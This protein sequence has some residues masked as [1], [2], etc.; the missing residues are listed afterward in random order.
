MEEE[1]QQQEENVIDLHP[2]KKW[3]RILV[4]LG[5]FF[6]SF[7]LSFILFNV[8][9]FPLAKVICHTG[10]KQNQITECE[11]TA[12]NLLFNQKILFED[13]TYTNFTYHVNYTFKVF[14]SYYAFDQESGVDEN[15]PQYGHKLENEVIRHYFIDIKGDSA[16]Y[17]SAFNEYNSDN[18][19]DIGDTP[20]SI[21]LKSEY[22]NLLGSEL[23]EVKDEESYSEV[24]TNFRDHLF[25]RLFYLKVY[26]DILDNDLIVDGVSYNHN[27]NR[28]KS[29]NQQLQWVASVSCM[30]TMLLS[31][32]IFYIL[33]PCLHKDRKTLT[34]MVM[35]IEPIDKKTLASVRRLQIV[36][37]SFYQIVTNMAYLVFLPV[38]YFGISYCFNL[39]LL[40]AFSLIS[41]VYLIASLFIIIFNQYNQSG[42]DLLSQIVLIPTSELD[43]MYKPK[44]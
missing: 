42:S 26:Q 6:I 34:T 38:L 4:F 1:L 44:E 19:F 2:V 31:W 10:D 29:I 39:P 22:R 11:K 37:N 7:I 41:V 13:K 43:N 40:F 27:M 23:L 28:I 24:M 9:I 30:I 18:Y 35:N 5:D 20:E 15:H 16:G 12:N 21:S 36:V 32:S 33:I 17:L 3:K 8:A 25:A 14:L